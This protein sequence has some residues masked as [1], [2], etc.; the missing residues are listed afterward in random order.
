TAL[1]SPTGTRFDDTT[2][3]PLS[4]HTYT[5]TAVVG[6]ESPPSA[7]ASATAQAAPDTAAPTTPGAIGTSS[8]TSSSVKLT[9]G[10]STDNVGIEGYRVL[11]GPSSS[12]LA[13]IWTTDAVA[14]YTATHLR[15]NT[16]YWFGVQAL[17]AGNNVS[18]IQKISITTTTSTDTTKPSAPSS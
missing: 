13:D 6:S 1:A 9:W 5:V 11:R 15:A 12:Q 3:L 10:A 14:S 7:P 8:L 2:V 18:A 4:T 17:D 16:T